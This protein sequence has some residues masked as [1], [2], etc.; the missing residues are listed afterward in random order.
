MYNK[1]E[2]SRNFPPGY[3]SVVKTP[4]CVMELNDKLFIQIPWWTWRKNKTLFVGKS[5]AQTGL[6]W[7]KKKQKL[8]LS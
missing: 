7:D 1:A 5:G 3:T 8:K 4:S 6:F 2:R